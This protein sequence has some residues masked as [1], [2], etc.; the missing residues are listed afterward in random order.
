MGFI[1]N[2]LIM[3]TTMVTTS[4][5]YVVSVNSPPPVAE[6]PKA[7]LHC[8]PMADIRF[9]PIPSIPVLSAADSKSKDASDTILVNK[10]QELR[11]YARSQQERV[12]EARLAHLRACL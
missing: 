7:V 9:D 2:G 4:C 6:P 8:P 12:N 3:T 11:D 1:H 5:I 10:I